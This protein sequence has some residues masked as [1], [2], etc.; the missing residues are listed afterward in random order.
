MSHFLWVAI[1]LGAADQPAVLPVRSLTL[2]R[3]GT[4]WVERAAEVVVTQGAA[5]VAIDENAYPATWTLS[6]KEPAAKPLAI[7]STPFGPIPADLLSDVSPREN[8]ALGQWLSL[9][10]KGETVEGELL[11]VEPAPGGQ[12]LAVRTQNGMAWIHSRSLRRVMRSP[13]AHAT[14]R[15]PEGVKKATVQTSALVEGVGWRPSYRLNIGPEGQGRLTLTAILFNSTPQE[16]RAD[17]AECSLLSLDRT[18]TGT[19]S[20]DASN[21]DQ[22]SYVIGPL[23][24]NPLSAT[25]VSSEQP[26]IS[27]ADLEVRVEQRF[28]WRVGGLDPR[29]GT[30]EDSDRVEAVLVVTT[31]AQRALASGPAVVMQAERP[32]AITEFPHCP[33]GQAAEVRL[34]AT[35]DLQ[36]KREETELDRK[37]GVGMG[38]EQPVDWVTFAGTLAIENQGIVPARVRVT[39]RFAGEGTAASDEG[40]IQR[41]LNQVGL[42]HPISE[43][44][45]EV[46]IPRGQIKRLTYGY[47][48]VVPSK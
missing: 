4:S 5:S 42:L 31:G 25:P 9:Q 20:S 35:R 36:V 10:T 6:V 16:L 18:E 41:V 8:S 13:V 19:E 14:V 3:D 32:L 23:V 40:R 33:A 21:A 1:L 17:Q 12:R 39:K 37:R 26:R 15:F 29:S 2:Y 7:V 28:D 38:E 11:A 47:R 30:H 46:T 22:T 44:L 34:G 27:L 43:I 45:W 24:L 48:M